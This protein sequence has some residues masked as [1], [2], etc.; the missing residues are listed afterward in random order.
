MRN[1]NMKKKR[2]KE[3]KSRGL[4]DMMVLENRNR[5]R[6]RNRNHLSNVY[7]R[8]KTDYFYNLNLKNNIFHILISLF[9]Y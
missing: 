6:N 8:T 5:N 4:V 9:L 7:S 2:K 1:E 3:R